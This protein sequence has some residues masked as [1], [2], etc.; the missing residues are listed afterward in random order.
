MNLKEKNFAQTTL[1]FFNDLP[2][3]IQLCVL[4]SPILL[5]CAYFVSTVIFAEYRHLIDDIIHFAKI[6]FLST[7][8][9]TIV[10]P[11]VCYIAKKFG[12]TDNSNSVKGNVPLLGG[13][14]IFLSFIAV[15][16]LFKPWT[17][18]MK[19][20]LFAGSIIFLIG[21]LDDIKPLSSL[22]RLIGQFSATIIVLSSGLVISFLPQTFSGNAMAYV[23]TFMWIIGV[24]NA[25][26]FI[27]GIDGLAS[28]VTLI[29][30]FFFFLITLHLG[31]YNVSLLSTVLGGICLGF[32]FHNFKPA[33][34]Y[35]GDGGS[36]FLGFMLAC[37]ALYGQ[38][39]EK[40]HVVALG[41]PIL[42]LGVLVFDMTYITISRVKNGSV[43]NLREWLDYKGLDHFHHRL[44][45]L[46]FKEEQAVIFIYI[47]C[48][49]LGI[50]ALVLE[51]SQLAYH[52]ILLISQA[53]L[54]FLCIT[55]LMLVG[56]KK[57]AEIN[58]RK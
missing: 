18:Q 48:F 56:R 26:N 7:G 22:F 46:G 9:V 8:L 49:I 33:R 34:I 16:F 12:I 21:T 50:S 27:D 57:S 20:I 13:I 14:A 35:L 10:T 44:I 52:V 23:I 3:K 19:A 25:M 11:I 2:I 40:G 38:W 41:I 4:L 28:G 6:G 39:S 30:S 17:T 32:L 45:N 15:L 47:V 43:T 55:I 29:A 51:K 53:T 1:T 31:Q 54:F 42:I 24:T 58:S 37:V 36:T 5:I